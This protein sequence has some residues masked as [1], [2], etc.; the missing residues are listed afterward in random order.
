MEKLSPEDPNFKIDLFQ[1][2]IFGSYRDETNP[3]KVKMC[4][5]ALLSSAADADNNCMRE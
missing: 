2:K 3:T 1:N 4:P 5:H